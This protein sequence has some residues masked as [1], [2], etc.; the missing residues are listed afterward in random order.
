MRYPQAGTANAIVTLHVFDV[1][2][3]ERIDV[4]WD[5][6]EH[7]EYLARVDWSEGSPLTLLVESRDQRTTRV[8]EVDHATGTTSVVR[9]DVDQKWIDLVEGAPSRLN[10][11]GLVSTM[12]ADDTR[13][14]A[15][16]G[17]P[18]TEP[19]LDVA[20]VLDSG[21]DVVFTASEH[22]DPTETHVWRVVPGSDPVRLSAEPG[23][24]TAAVGGEVAAL[25]SWGADEQHPR[26]TV[27][28]KGEVV[29]T[30]DSHAEAPLV[31]PRPTYASL[32]ER[33]LRAALLVPGGREL[34]QRM[35]VLL[36]PYGGPHFREVQ[37]WRGTYREAQFY[38]DRLGVAVLVIDGRG[39]PGRGTAWEREL[40][41]DFTITLQDQ[42]DGLH[43]AA[44]RWSFL[45][46]DR[47]AIM[48]WSFGGLL[49]AL[50]VIDRPDAFHAA[51][52][53]APVTDMHLYDTHYTE[54]YLGLPEQEPEAYRKSSPLTRAEQLRRPLFLIQG[55]ADDNVVAAN[56]LQ[57][58]GRLFSA[59][60]HHE[61]ALLSHASHMGGFDELV[62]GQFLA[63][64]DFL[65]RSLH[66]PA[67]DAVP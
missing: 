57:L 7:F 18:V 60:I 39:T 42:V 3:G 37:R 48:G 45:D 47:V 19:G 17:K 53:G 13:R 23:V 29:A 15:I 5:D 66:L 50:A 30:I 40:Y 9:E 28:R 62:V 12:V 59:G 11:G 10:D 49:A 56:T 31:D 52:S 20:D 16:D 51:V 24:H 14:L 67:A 21:D 27:V 26:V 35:P 55:L 25:K 63:V 4:V 58:S 65:R 1:A 32:G 38:A 43:A 54:R 8:L 44:D 22:A 33:Q 64:L 41:R 61:L 2:T 36:A 34:Q 6:P 46:L